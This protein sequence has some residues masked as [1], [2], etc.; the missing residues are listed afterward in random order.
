MRV[1]YDRSVNRARSVL[2]PSLVA[3]M[4]RKI[5]LE[6]MFEHIPV[7]LKICP[8]WVTWAGSKM[9]FDPAMPNSL[10]SVT[11][12]NTWG[13][14]EAA[15]T[16]YEEGGRD[17]VGFVLNGDGLVGIDLDGCV[18]RGMPDPR[19]I[20][21]LDR[22]GSRYIE[23]SPSGHGL[24]SFGFSEPPKRCK[25]VMDGI[26]VEIYSTARYLTVTGHV[27]REGPII[28][29][30]GFVSVSD[31]LAP[32]EEHRSAQSITEDDSSHLQ[33][34]SVGIPPNTIP[35]AKSER[36]KRLFELAR[37]LKG[38]MP[39]ATLAELRVIVNEWHRLALPAIGT[40]DF[41]ITWAD[42]TRGWQKVRFP[43]GATLTTVLEG[44]DG[45]PLPDGIAALGYGDHGKALIKI[46]SRLASH[47][48]PEPFFISARQAGELLNIHFTDASK[49]LSAL[50]ADRVIDVVERGSGKRASRYRWVFS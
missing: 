18:E 4:K 15:K 38:T 3:T 19:A 24:R 49:L 27:F 12:P 30:P 28:E 1:T 26:N 41:G 32:T 31:E 9:P 14:F 34:S 2:G 5:L 40:K 50:V 11:D 39:N 13:N 36:N 7:A 21:L 35:T 29:L 48:D 20:A 45:D 43:A 42:F 25:G 37:Y 47:H 33:Y 23:F 8:R 22:I 6:P 10:A 44:C 16:A 17:G 46:C